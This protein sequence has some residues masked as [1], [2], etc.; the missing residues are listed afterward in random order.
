MSRFLK[1][2]LR[3]KPVI[4]TG[5]LASENNIFHHALLFYRLQE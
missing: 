1:L 2:L 4:V 5:R 3:Q